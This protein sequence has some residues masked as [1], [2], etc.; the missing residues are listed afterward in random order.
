MIMGSL[1]EAEWIMLKM[2]G[3]VI[4]LGLAIL[5][6]LVIGRIL[7]WKYPKFD[8]WIKG[9]WPNQKQKNLLW[10]VVP[11]LIILFTIFK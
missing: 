1:L 8:Q 5:L 11:T 9:V 10:V 2:S 4:A 6:P 7:M 3:Q